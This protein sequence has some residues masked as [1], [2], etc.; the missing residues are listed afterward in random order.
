MGRVLLSDINVLENGSMKA[1]KDT[2]LVQIE[3]TNACTH[4]CLHCT[5]FVGYHPPSLL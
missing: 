2:W 3:I 5:R 4:Q 1:I